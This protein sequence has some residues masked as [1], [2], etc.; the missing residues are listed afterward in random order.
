MV[1]FARY[2]TSNPDLVKRLYEGW[3]LTPYDRLSF[4]G[5]SNWGYNT[6]NHYNGKFQFTKDIESNKLPK[7]IEEIEVK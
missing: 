1:G 4:Y 5:S 7:A 6:F 3:D 2:Y